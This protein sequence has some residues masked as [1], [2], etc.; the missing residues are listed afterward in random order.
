MNSPLPDYF[1]TLQTV[2]M[3]FFFQ[4]KAGFAKSFRSLLKTT[5]LLS[6]LATT[7][8]Y[9]QLAPYTLKKPLDFTI[10][11]IGLLHATANF[12]VKPSSSALQMMPPNPKLP[13]PD[14]WFDY[15]YRPKIARGS[16]IT[17]AT[18]VALPIAV[19]LAGNIQSNKVVPVIVAAE[20][21]WMTWNLTESVKH[22]VK[23]NRPLVYAANTPDEIRFTR[24]ARLSFPS[25]HTSMVFCM[26]TA[27]HLALKQYNI[28]LAERR[29]LSGSAWML[30]AGTAGMRVIAGKHY[31]SDILAGAALGFG[32]AYLMH[33]IH[34]PR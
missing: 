21:M 4:R 1:T 5:A 22:L 27:F 16:D 33:H 19:L 30:A 13:P 18:T 23:R 31:P 17:A 24:D 25:G 34:A 9:A 29:W 8:L 3:R 15:T 20:A 10:S 11:G 6:G 12:V 26:A 28:P 32:T 2:M 14:R 7:G